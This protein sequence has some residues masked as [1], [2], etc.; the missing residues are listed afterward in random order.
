MG[1][2]LYVGGQASTVQGEPYDCP[3]PR[4][5]TAAYAPPPIPPNQE[6]TILDSGAFSD[7]P[8]KRLTPEQ[9]LERQLAYERKAA[10]RWGEGW[11]ATRFVS[12]DLLIDETWVNGKKHKRRWSLRQG[13]WAVER[14][15]EAAHYLASQ[16][17]AITPR[18]LI[19][20]AQGVDAI[21]Y[22]ECVRQ[23]LGVA[24]PEDWIGLGGWC[25]LG[26]YTSYLPAFWQSLR[27]CLPM[28][29][30]SG[31]NHVH[32]FGVLYQPALGGLLWLADEQGLTVSTDSTAPVLAC[33]KPDPKRAGVRVASGYWRDNVAWWK[34]TLANLRHSKHYKEPPKTEAFRQMSF[35]D[36]VA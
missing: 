10:K 3:G 18:Q 22:E 11:T 29:K 21:Q 5:L 14:T 16:R 34:D 9:A 15:V 32:I 33:T 4:M 1:V 8:E 36:E 28:I 17:E 20:S 24:T 2:E 31:V 6:S 27:S 35:L 7:K 23:V 26:R 19:L 12:Y 13:E 30:A 25:I